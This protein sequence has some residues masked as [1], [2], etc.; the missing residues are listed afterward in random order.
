MSL[1]ISYDENFIKTI[2]KEEIVK[3]IIESDRL[4]QFRLK[5]ILTKEMKTEEQAY[6]S[7]FENEIMND[8]F[9]LQKYNNMKK[10]RSR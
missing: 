10:Q 6:R 5:L 7:I 9:R 8:V 4:L 2:Y 3:E 1:S